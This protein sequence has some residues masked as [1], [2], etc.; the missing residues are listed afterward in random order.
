MSWYKVT[1]LPKDAGVGGRAKSLQAALEIL[2]MAN[3]APLDAAMFTNHD[4][5]F[6]NY[7]YY[8]SP[9]AA[10]IARNLIE[11]Y[12]GV[13]CSAP[14]RQG[15]ALLVGHSGAHETLLPAGENN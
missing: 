12:A 8:F 2:F 15:T 5:D 11:I 10:Q 1:L 6:K 14:P 4:D 3:A 9:G 7:F 13:Q